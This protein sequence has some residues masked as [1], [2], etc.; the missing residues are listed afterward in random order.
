[1]RTKIVGHVKSTTIRYKQMLEEQMTK[2]LSERGS[3]LQGMV[4]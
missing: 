4:R 1:M 2:N 3:R